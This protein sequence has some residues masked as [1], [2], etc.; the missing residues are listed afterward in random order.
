MND[1]FYSPN[2]YRV[3][4]LQ[5]NLHSHIK[6]HRHNYR[7]LIWYL[8]EDTTTGRSHRLN[9]AAYQF[10]GLLD[11]SLTVEETYSTISEQLG[12]FV[13]GQEDIVQLLG[14]LHAADLINT[15]VMAD[16][17]ELFARQVSQKQQ[18]LQQYISNP[19][20][21]KVPLWDPE[22]FLNKHFT[23]VQWLFSAWVAI[24]W[25]LLMAYTFIEVIQ[26]WPQ[27]NQHFAINALAPNNLLLIVLLYP[28]IKILHELGHAFS[29]KL[30]GGEVHEMGVN[31]MLF[32]PIP[33]VN[34]STATHFRNKYKR[35]LVSAAGILVE[36]FLAALGLLLFL[37][38]EPG[39][40][41]DIGFNIFIIGGISS[42]F[43]NGN[44]LLKFDAY[45]I[46]ADALAI[47]NLYQ[48][49]GQY[50]HYLFQRYL[51]GI[52]SANSP[53][54]SPGENLW[55]AIYGFLSQT[56]KL[57]VM[58]F[59]VTFVSDLSFFAG[60]VLAI[61]LISLQ[62][63]LP[64]WKALRFIA[65]NPRLGQK[66]GR[67]WAITAGITGLVIAVLGF[68]PVPSYTMTEGVV[69]QAD[70]AQ[71]IAAEGGFAGIP[72]VK[73]N[74]VI[75]AGTPVLRLDDLF[76]ESQTHIT[77]A[78]IRE[79]QSQYRANLIKDYVQAGII[80]DEIRIAE[81]ELHY[82]REKAQ[83]MWV[84][85]AKAGRV[86]LPEADDLPGRFVRK[87]DL[88]G[89]ILEDD[90]ALTIRMAV[91]Q[92]HIGQL[93]NHIV[94]ISVRFVSELNNVYPATLIRQTPEA[95]NQLPSAA[96]S[97]RGGGKFI[98]DPTT[99][100]GL[101][102]TEKVFLVDVELNAKYKTIPL[103]TRAYIRINHG[104]EPLASQWY[105]RIRQTFLRLLNV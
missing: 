105:R 87:G 100:N 27:I 52:T 54:Y 70:N 18:R 65:C 44:P 19:L 89:Y 99:T 60:I 96:L 63:C 9:S 71:L 101:I 30:E 86:L 48:R 56:Y 55:L 82:L 12:D 23:K 17:E 35:I 8:L 68:V 94:D 77:I 5:P 53:A 102:I 10:I 3:A 2:W 15:N 14:Q 26:H 43:F 85:S 74:Q 81:S 42:L 33:Y 61:W 72:L 4:K 103:G 25:L 57:I 40:I 41:Q 29:A 31:F 91:T 7:G 80:K 13:P 59:I 97:I 50:W 84:K 46:L 16:T 39:L 98:V 38:A 62:L 49:S 73:N 28:L 95:I 34:V 47:P 83:A 64:L 58:W 36:S 11:G 66:R 21:L 32:M 22:D 88:L 76:L 51:F 6:I 78:R 104:G 90:L 92:D 1:G 20:S 79:L 75:E 37:M 69:W 45:Y 67:V 24:A 93:R